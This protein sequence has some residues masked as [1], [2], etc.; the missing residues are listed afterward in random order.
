MYLFIYM[1]MH[2]HMLEHVWRSK[3]NVQELVLSCYHVIL[4]IQL[5]SSGLSS[6]I[7]FYLLRRLA[8]SARIFLEQGKTKSGICHLLARVPSSQRARFDLTHSDTLKQECMSIVMC[9]KSGQESNENQ[10]S[11]RWSWLFDLECPCLSLRVFLSLKWERLCDR[12][13][14][15]WQLEIEN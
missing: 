15:H 4:K 7:I 6:K 1:Y 13:S 3:D 2:V 14:L 8:T 12:I 5:R 9:T 11:S 10:A